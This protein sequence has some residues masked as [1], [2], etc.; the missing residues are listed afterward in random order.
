MNGKDKAKRV[1]LRIKGIIN[2]IDLLFSLD[3]PCIL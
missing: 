3:K 2:S 1:A